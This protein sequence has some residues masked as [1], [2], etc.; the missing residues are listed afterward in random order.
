MRKGRTTMKITAKAK[1]MSLFLAAALLT[2]C[3]ASVK[4]P[5]DGE[6]DTDIGEVKTDVKVE[7]DDGSDSDSNES[8]KSNKSNESNKSTQPE[9]EKDSDDKPDNGLQLKNPLKRKDNLNFV[10]EAGFAVNYLPTDDNLA[11]DEIY[12]IEGTGIAEIR[13]GTVDEAVFTY[14]IAVETAEDI[15]G[16]Y[17]SSASEETLTV[18]GVEE[19]KISQFDT[20]YLARWNYDGFSYSLYAECCAEDEFRGTL[21][22][23]ILYTMV[24]TEEQRL[25]GIL[26]T[27]YDKSRGPVPEADAEF[28][29]GGYGDGEDHGVI[30]YEFESVIAVNEG[31]YVSV[32]LAYF[33]EDGTVYSDEIDSA[34]ASKDFFCVRI[35]DFIPE[36]MPTYTVDVYYDRYV[37]TAYIMYDGRGERPTFPIYAD[38]TRTSKTPFLFD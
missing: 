24:D 5:S 33:G 30:P 4:T 18:C 32:N 31:S 36:T 9:N 10:E 14:R 23:L 22:K 19:V 17:N 2:S 21:D 20:N 38:E 8:N 13:M 37:G 34:V 27:G 25:L 6:A 15:S 12:F 11:V 26:H 29:Y 35:G 16:V 3:Q 1:V 28:D 7:T